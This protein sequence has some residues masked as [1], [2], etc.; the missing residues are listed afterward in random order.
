MVGRTQKLEEACNYS[1][2]K[3]ADDGQQAQGPVDLQDRLRGQRRRLCSWASTV[4]PYFLL[5]LDQAPHDEERQDQPDREDHYPIGPSISPKPIYDPGS[6]RSTLPKSFLTS[7]LVGMKNKNHKA[8]S[9]ITIT[10]KIIQA[11]L[12]N[13]IPRS[14]S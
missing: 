3:N 9:P 13:V 2:D 14:F 8:I 6:T 5:A 7:L 4:P 12:S 11:R 1:R 10:K